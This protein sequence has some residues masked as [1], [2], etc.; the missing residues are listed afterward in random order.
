MTT[1]LVRFLAA[2]DGPTAVEYAAMPA[3]IIEVRVGAATTV[4]SK[5]N[6]SYSTTNVKDP[7]GS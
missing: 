2:E 1:T 6:S 5:T 4:G 7:V 3:L